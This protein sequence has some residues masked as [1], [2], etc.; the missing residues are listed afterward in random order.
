MKRIIILLSLLSFHFTNYGQNEVDALRYTFFNPTG[1]ARYTSLGGAMGALGGDLSAVTFNPAGIALFRGNTM[2]FTPMWVSNATKANYYGENHSQHK[3]K[4]QMANIGFVSSM[5]YAWN[6]ESIKFVNFGVSYNQLGNF[7]RNVLISGFN[8]K[9]SLLD[10]ETNKVINGDKNNLFQKAD[11]IYTDPKDSTKL[12]ND[13]WRHGY[14]SQQSKNIRSEGSIGEYTI[15]GGIN[16]RNRLYIG[17]ALGIVRVS[18][19]ETSEHTEDP[20]ESFPDLLYFN[21]KNYFKTSGSGM[22]FKIGV[23]GRVTDWL[24]LGVAIHT[25]TAF[26]LED[27]YNSEVNARIDY[28]NG[29]TDRQAKTNT[30]H[31]EWKVTTPF[32]TNVSAA[33]FWGKLGLLSVDYEIVNYASINMEGTDYDFLTENEKIKKIYR[34][35]QN[36]KIGLEYNLGPISFRGGYA[37]LASP[38]SSKFD[39]N[40]ANYSVYSAGIGLKTNRF[41]V[42]IAGKYTSNQEYFYLYGTEDSKAKIANTHFSYLATIG[43]RF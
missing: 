8:D 10:I 35:A 6:D 14:G 23:I 11:L 33:L 29:I 21:S 41:F 42:D 19:T 24:R 12:T 28:K 17:G 9:G 32:R 36:L 37:F 7:N 39:N 1:T 5:K 34:Y 27:T 25:P 30:S 26:N 43:I 4:L 2:A 16:F 22:N 20:P 18:Y 31:Y 3:Y 15:S 40:K 38:F 13:F